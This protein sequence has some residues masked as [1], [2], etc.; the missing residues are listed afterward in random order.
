MHVE[1]TGSQALADQVLVTVTLQDS[2]QTLYQ[3]PIGALRT[4][5]TT[6]GS[7]LDQTLRDGRAERVSIT[8]E[9]PLSAGNDVQ[10]ASLSVRVIVDSVQ[11]AA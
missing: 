5:G 9:L 1:W 7:P 4:G 11:T 2:G 6:W 3:G 8:G 10:G